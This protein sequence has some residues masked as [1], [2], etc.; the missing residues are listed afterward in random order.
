MW[1]HRV[2]LFVTVPLIWAAMGCL[3][4][5]RNDYHSSRPLTVVDPSP[6]ADRIWES[7]QDALRHHRFRLDRVDRRAG[8]ITTIPETSQSLVE[9]WRHDVDT[10]PD[11][12]EATLNPI[13]RWVEVI[14]SR[15][16]ESRWSELAIVVHKERLSSP[17][18]QFKHRCSLSVFRREPAFDRRSRRGHTRGR[19][20]ARPRSGSGHGGMSAERDNRERR[21]GG[22]SRSFP[23]KAAD[24][25]AQGHPVEPAD[26]L[27]VP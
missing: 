7:A 3:G 26:V 6:Q 16:E 27:A 22:R 19:C 24:R 21:I 2:R 13:R 8:I 18:R 10:W 15:R 14:V 9:F 11:L 17:D 4:P 5:R 1:A 20:M 25:F 23:L 12:W